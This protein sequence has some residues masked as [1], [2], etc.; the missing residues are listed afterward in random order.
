MPLLDW[1]KGEDDSEELLP[2]CHTTR[3][4]YFVKI[5]KEDNLSKDHS[6]FPD[7]NPTSLAEEKVVYLFYGLPFYIYELEG[8]SSI[9]SEV[10]ADVPIGL[11]FKASLSNQVD[12]L[13]PFDTGAFFSDM[14]NQNFQVDKKSE[15]KDYMVPVTDGTEMK[16]IVKRY[17]DTNIKYCTGRPNQGV[18]ASDYQEENLISLI[19]AS[20]KSNV[21]LRCRAIELHSKSDVIISS[22]LQAIV[23]PRFRTKDYKGTLDEVKKK[24][25]SVKQLFY[26]DFGRFGIEELRK[27]IMDTTMDYY[28]QDTNMGFSYT[29]YN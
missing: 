22:N 3:W 19:K 21:D 13:Y 27:S 6:K 8:N 28:D 17:F 10:T 18:I 23:L 20:G 14:L 15:Y 26:N 16:Q 11:I 12:R 5:L 1:I 7:P 24:H 29:N 2:L 25:P 4:K 9:Y